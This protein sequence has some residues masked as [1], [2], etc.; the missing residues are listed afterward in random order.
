[1]RKIS[2]YVD[3]RLK[4]FNLYNYMEQ[5]LRNGVADVDDDIS[6]D[7]AQSIALFSEFVELATMLDDYSSWSDEKWTSFLTQMVIAFK[8]KGKPD[9]LNCVLA[10][11]G[12]K[13]VNDTVIENITDSEGVVTSYVT[14]TIET[15]STPNVAE[16]KS[17]LEALLP[18]ILWLHSPDTSGIEVNTVLVNIALSDT[19]IKTL[20][21]RGIKYSETVGSIS[22][23]NWEV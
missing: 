1:M 18:K 14:L 21:D 12:I 2:L 20:Y 16:F 6:I 7:E 4:E 9:A 17:R 15:L 5:I 23:E 11:L 13:T 22:S 19:Y 3:S 10:A 8:E